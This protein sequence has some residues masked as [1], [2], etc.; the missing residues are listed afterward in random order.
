M[1]Q[2]EEKYFGEFFPA[3]SRSDDVCRVE[4]ETIG[5][6]VE[7]V[8]SRFSKMKYI[9][10]LAI[11]FTLLAQ[12]LSIHDQ[13]LSSPDPEL[14][15]E[16][17]FKRY[18]LV[19]ERGG[20][21]AN[22]LTLTIAGQSFGIRRLEELVRNYFY[23]KQKLGYPSAYVYNT[24]QWTKY[25]D[26]LLDVFQLSTAGRFRLL[27]EL[28]KFGNAKIETSEVAVLE[29]NEVGPFERILREYERSDKS[30]NGGLAYQAIAYGFV[31]QS[32]NHLSIIADK[33]RT[34]SARQKRI[35]DID[36]Y[37]GHLLAA[38]FEV[39]DLELNSDNAL[40]EV[41]DFK[42][43][44]KNLGVLGIVICKD[45]SNELTE[46]LHAFGT[47]VITEPEL[48]TIVSLWDSRKQELS[49]ESTL[50]YLANIEQNEKAV[51]RLFEFLCSDNRL[52][53][54]GEQI[55]LDMQS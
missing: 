37:A 36:A 12:Q 29:A 13:V 55:R 48:T 41:G 15:L 11:D 23:E 28:L 26:L 27:I 9:L 16:N 32:Y 14:T 3:E 34:G 20:K 42:N 17:L 54:V 53:R 4:N 10:G 21:K 33:V 30:E 44:V 1:N 39:K 8:S 25:Q 50:H 24:G 43:K 47:R 51:R 18:H 22:T 38:T 35:G 6:C 49:I 45:C 46:G 31:S 2:I 52:A 7:Y 5:R 19:T 40:R